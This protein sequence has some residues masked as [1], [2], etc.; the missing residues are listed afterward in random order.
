MR[1]LTAA[2]ETDHEKLFNLPYG[3]DE[4]DLDEP[5]VSV[6]VAP[7]VSDSLAAQLLRNGLSLDR[8]EL[9]VPVKIA[10]LLHGMRRRVITRWQR[11]GL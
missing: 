5:P 2:N 6:N 8:Q 4:I 7:D 1:S 11:G 10:F 3:Y 9:V